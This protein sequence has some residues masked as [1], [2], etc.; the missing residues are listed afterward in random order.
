MNGVFLLKMK[1]QIFIELFYKFFDFMG[2]QSKCYPPM[3]DKHN[4]KPCTTPYG[5]K[6]E[7]SIAYTEAYKEHIIYNIQRLL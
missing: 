4:H 5:R 6:R 1:Q 2:R 7:I 3:N